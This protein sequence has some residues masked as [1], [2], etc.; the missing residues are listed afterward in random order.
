VKPLPFA[1]LAAIGFATV[2]FSAAWLALL[3]WCWWQ[4]ERLQH[5][6][7]ERR[8]ARHREYLLAAALQRPR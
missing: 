6:A 8:D 1:V 4:R 7:A 2:W 3:P 5:E